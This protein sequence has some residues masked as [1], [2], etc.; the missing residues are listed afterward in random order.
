MIQ[1]LKKVLDGMNIQYK[2]TGVDSFQFE[3]NVK[4]DYKADIITGHLKLLKKHK[5]YINKDVYKYV[6]SFS[7]SDDFDE[8]NTHNK[9]E[10]KSQKFTMLKYAQFEKQLAEF[11]IERLQKE[12]LEQPLVSNSTSKMTNLKFEWFLE[13]K[14]EL[15]SIYKQ[16]V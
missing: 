3:K 14:Q 1:N 15:I 11:T 8:Q 4:I 13:C 16:F 12:L 2:L 5:N 7:F 10:D 9:L 6:R